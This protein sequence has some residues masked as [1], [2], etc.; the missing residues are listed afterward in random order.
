[1]ANFNTFRLGNTYGQREG[2]NTIHSDTYNT[3]HSN[4]IY[5]TPGVVE[6]HLHLYVCLS[7]SLCVC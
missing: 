4:M 6:S 7:V 3:V 5:I 1:M 2:Y